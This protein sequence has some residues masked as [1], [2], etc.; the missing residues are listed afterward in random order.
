MSRICGAIFD[1]SSQEMV[2]GIVALTQSAPSSSLG[3]NSPP[4]NGTNRSVRPKMTA[5]PHMVTTGRSRHQSSFLLYHF[6]IASNGR[7]TFSFTP[8]LNQYEAST[9]TNVKV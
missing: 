2:Y 7:F 9:G 3:M 1:A 4:M 8:F 5:A 6:L